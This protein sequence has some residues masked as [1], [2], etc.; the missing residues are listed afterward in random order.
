M[1]QSSCNTG[2]PLDTGPAAPKASGAEAE[3]WTLGPFLLDGGPD[4]REA[5]RSSQ[6]NERLP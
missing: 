6:R 1:L 3:A 4:T 2:Q 5:R